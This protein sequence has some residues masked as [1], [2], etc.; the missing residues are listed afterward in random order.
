MLKAPSCLHRCFPKRAAGSPASTISP[1]RLEWQQ[2][3]GALGPHRP[4]LPSTCA[5]CCAGA[6]PAP[7][8]RGTCSP[9]CELTT[10][11]ISLITITLQSTRLQSEQ[12]PADRE[13]KHHE[14]NPR[15]L[16][17]ELPSGSGLCW[18][19]PWR[20][21]TAGARSA[22]AL[23]RLMSPEP[24]FSQHPGWWPSGPVCSERGGQGH[25]LEWRS[26][27]HPASQTHLGLPGAMLFH[28]DTN[29]QLVERKCLPT[30]P[31]GEKPGI[32]PPASPHR[33]PQRGCSALPQRNPRPHCFP[34][35]PWTT[36]G[37]LSV[38]E[39]KSPACINQLYL[40]SLVILS[41][42]GQTDS[43]RGPKCSKSCLSLDLSWVSYS[44]TFLHKEL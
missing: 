38:C 34:S 7:V 15:A 39:V 2:L 27:Q 29:S 12:E 19:L 32:G 41:W 26:R 28:S 42:L 40:S 33:A 31:T 44:S 20:L 16:R 4:S 25:A 37:Y 30:T 17:S 24:L 3:W 23:A 11:G 21:T 6:A 5:V 36:S 22:A 43:T 14:T 10:D 8:Y 9:A 18:Q 35:D 1:R 13:R